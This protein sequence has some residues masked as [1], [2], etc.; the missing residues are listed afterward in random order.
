MTP[1]HPQNPP[2]L[3]FLQIQ[4]LAK[5]A[6]AKL[7]AAPERKREKPLRRQVGHASLLAALTARIAGYT[8][9][10]REEEEEEREMD[11]LD[12]M[13]ERDGEW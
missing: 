8:Q 6:A 13:L 5:Q 2:A 9:E 4:G 3:S 10:E 11:W 1:A 7:V 12:K